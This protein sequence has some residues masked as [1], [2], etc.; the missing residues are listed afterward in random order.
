MEMLASIGELSQLEFPLQVRIEGD[1]ALVVPSF[2]ALAVCRDFL[3]EVRGFEH[4]RPAEAMLSMDL[5][6]LRIVYAEQIRRAD[7]QLRA[8]ASGASLAGPIAMLG[9]GAWRPDEEPG[10]SI[11]WDLVAA[12]RAMLDLDHVDALQMHAS[13]SEDPE[14]RREETLE[15]LLGSLS[16]VRLRVLLAEGSRLRPVL[17]TLRPAPRDADA[18]LLLRA[19]PDRFAPAFAAWCRPLAEFAK[20]VG[21]PAER[22]VVRLAE[23]LSAWDGLLGVVEPP[24]PPGAYAI[25]ATVRGD[26]IGLAA[27][28]EWLEP[29]LR[30]AGA[31]D[32]PSGGRVE[33]LADGRRCFRDAAG[34]IVLTTGRAGPVQWWVAGD[35]AAPASETLIRFAQVRDVA[36]GP[37]LRARVREA[38][39]ELRQLGGETLVDLAFPGA[40]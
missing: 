36:E 11:N 21:A 38:R 17:E 14:G 20:G 33:E 5:A 34:D 2:E 6:Q 27:L 12:V 18:L 25:L 22:H 9:T 32:V 26:G 19:D 10:L 37:A 4:A 15:A 7:Q 28:A 35:G 29:L 1:H 24:G 16:S 23:L 31:E 8:L 3:Q 39:V 30:S 13:A 40:N